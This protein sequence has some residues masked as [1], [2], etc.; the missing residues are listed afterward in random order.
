MREEASYANHSS[1]NDG[2]QAK[3]E[4][5]RSDSEYYKYSC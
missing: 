3:G 4:N 1:S 5:R 2:R